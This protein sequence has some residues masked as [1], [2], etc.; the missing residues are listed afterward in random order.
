MAEPA[1]DE[2]RANA[3]AEIVLRKTLGLRAGE[4]VTIESW[5]STLPWALSFVREARKIG[6]HPILLFEDEPN[7]WRSVAEAKPANLGAFGRH[8]AALLEKSDAYVFFLGPSDQARFERTN[9]ELGG[10]LTGFDESWYAIANRTQ[11]RFARMYL[12]LV[13]P[14]TAKRFRVHAPEWRENV[15]EASLVEPEEMHRPGAQIAKRFEEGTRL[16]L[17]HPN[18]TQLELQLKHRPAK[19]DSG[20]L[21]SQRR[22]RRGPGGSAGVRETPVPAGVVSVALDEEFAEGTIVANAPTRMRDAAW[23]GA[24]WEFSHGH[25]LSYRFVS[26]RAQFDRALASARRGRDQPGALSIGLNPK[27]HEAPFMVD[28]E[29]G[30]VTLSIGSNRHFGGTTDANF[31]AWASL[32]GADV[33]IDGRPI[34]RKGRIVVR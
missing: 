28:Q 25:L 30:T 2:V 14:S 29:L 8:E 21:P 6:A 13:S 22:S 3:V 34:L 26:G 9:A 23:S 31:F 32:R 15:I 10:Q 17:D 12:G 11:L 1:S 24:R 7:Y 33:A 18:G 20:L 16:S 19:L 4:T 27:L 5:S